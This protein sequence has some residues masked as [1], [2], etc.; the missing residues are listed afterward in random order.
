MRAEPANEAQAPLSSIDWDELHRRLNAARQAVEHGCAPTPEQKRRILKDR[1]RAAARPSHADAQPQDQFELLEFLLAQETYGI[2]SSFVR[3]V[4]PLK[5]LTPVPGT[6]AFVLGIT[7]LRGQILSVIDLKKVF[8]L[9]DKGLTDLNKIIVIGNAEME[10][11]ILAD[12]VLQV[13]KVPA[14]Q[15]QLS[16]PTLTGI[17]ASFLKG[18]TPD[19]LVALDGAKLL[20]SQSIVVNQPRG[21]ATSATAITNP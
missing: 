8:E 2:E 7:S 17:R 19:R 16:L 5:T 11:G 18:V 10:F 21:E 4:H 1:A 3:E 15:L 12:A 14:S 13:R 20:S 9:P 6:P